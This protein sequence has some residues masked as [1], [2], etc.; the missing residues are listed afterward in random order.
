[1]LRVTA[2]E[3]SIIESCINSYVD[4]QI[5]IVNSIKR[6]GLKDLEEVKQYNIDISKDVI[7][8]PCTI[9]TDIKSY[10]MEFIYKSKYYNRTKLT[11]N[12]HQ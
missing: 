12:L 10:A 3:F 1:M 2:C 7:I 8:F 4:L 5:T 9:S 11:N 6:P